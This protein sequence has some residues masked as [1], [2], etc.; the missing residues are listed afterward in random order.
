MELS[1]EQETTRKKRTR[2]ER[3]A[4]WEEQNL[5]ALDA[6]E[7]KP[8]QEPV[9][10]PVPLPPDASSAPVP[11]VYEDHWT[12]VEYPRH[13][14]I[15]RW[16]PDN[17]LFV[18]RLEPTPAVCLYDTPSIRRSIW[19]KE[20]EIRLRLTPLGR[21]AW[22]RKNELTPPRGYKVTVWPLEP[23]TTVA[24]PSSSISVARALHDAAYPPPSI[25]EA[26]GFTSE[27]LKS[28][29]DTEAMVETLRAIVSSSLYTRNNY[30]EIGPM[31]E[32]KEID[33]SLCENYQ[34]VK[35]RYV[36]D[37]REAHQKYSETVK[38]EF[39]SQISR[40]QRPQL[41]TDDLLA[42]TFMRMCTPADL[43]RLLTKTI[44]GD[45]Y[46]SGQLFV[47]PPSALTL[48]TRVFTDNSTAI[49]KTRARYENDMEAIVKVLA[50]CRLLMH[51]VDRD[52]QRPYERIQRILSYC[53]WTGFFMP[54]FSMDDKDAQ[55]LL[56]V[57]S[58]GIVRMS[59]PD[60]V[61]SRDPGYRGVLLDAS[62][63]PNVEDSKRCQNP[64]S[65]LPTPRQNPYD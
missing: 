12:G 23:D 9:Q 6:R 64:Y 57:F 21:V 46:S 55:D 11:T 8:V 51:R 62:M 33:L 31:L 50:K 54:T 19:M 20:E 38:A 65:Y 14:R 10:E 18:K 45:V 4:E 52:V 37:L 48:S 28:V 13:Q 59:S 32:L 15:A 26:E 44:A 60:S 5:K 34:A 39:S 35:E 63:D 25:L 36:A 22:L 58:F 49:Y 41:V 24:G 53:V 3:D 30:Y 7:K 29:F 56:Q 16:L 1:Y 17:P 2:A 61:T 43:E 47:T 27:H 40:A 42:R